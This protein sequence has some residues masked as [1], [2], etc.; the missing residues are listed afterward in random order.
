MDPGKIYSAKLSKLSISNVEFRIKLNFIEGKST[1][2]KF[3]F[4]KK[5]N[6]YWNQLSNPT[7]TS[8]L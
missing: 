6:L 7:K 1:F 5:S 2:D 3:K 4:K 8:T